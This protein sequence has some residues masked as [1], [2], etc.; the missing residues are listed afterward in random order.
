MIPS[1]AFRQRALDRLPALRYRNFRRYM[2]GQ[3]ASIAG[4]WLQSVALGWLVLE[5]TGDGSAVGLVISAQY[6]PALLL[7]VW[8]GAAADRYDARRAVVGL[9]V[10]LGAQAAALAALVFTHHAAV[11]SLCLLAMVQGVG[12]AF[13]QPIRQSLMNETV[14]DRELPNAIATNSTLVQIGLIL[15]PALAAVL[16]PTV[17]IGWCFVVNSA[18]YVVMFVAI[19]SIRPAEMIRRPRATGGDSS[20]RAG[21]AYVRRHGDIRLMLMVLAAGSLMAFR[22]EVV[23]PVLARRGLHGGSRLYAAMTVV[24]GLGSLVVSLHLASRSGPPPLKFLR[25]MCLVLALGLAATSVP[26][27][28]VALVGLVPVGFGMLGTVVSTLSLTQL[29]ASPEYRGRVVALWFVVMNGGVVLG[30]LLTG[31]I[32][33]HIGSRQALLIGSVMML[34]VWALL[35][36]AKRVLTMRTDHLTTGSAA[37]NVAPRHEGD[38]E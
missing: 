35:G 30:A 14:G 21:F 2:A 3:V 10:L 13:D 8:A 20:V 11:W 19:R 1:A 37:G 26:F 7:G 17:G 38:A 16:I 24:R 9:Q 28:G 31:T 23:L 4:T 25:W 32:V 34:A 6:V 36:R 15:G 27:T 22:L 5:L 29:L 33:E 18:S 12:N